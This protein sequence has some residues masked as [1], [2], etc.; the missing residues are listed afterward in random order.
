[1]IGALA[2]VHYLMH[3]APAP[4]S[5]TACAALGALDLEPELLRLVEVESRGVAVGVH[6]GHHPRT[7]GRVFW[8]KAV[9]R[10]V[11]RPDLCDEHMTASDESPEWGIRGAH[12]HAA[13]YAVGELG[14]CVPA[15]ALDVPFLSAIAAVR[16]LRKLSRSF[17]L[18]SPEARALAWRVGVGRARKLM[19]QNSNPAQ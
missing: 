1:M 8:D 2:L 14:E 4:A 7:P 3:L 17:G 11:L 18:R 12:G 13:P 6:T 16:R 5:V 15:A 10:G 19:R 9:E